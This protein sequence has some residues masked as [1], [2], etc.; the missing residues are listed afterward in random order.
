MLVLTR[1]DNESIQIGDHITIKVMEIS[2]GVVKLGIE[3]SDDTLILRSEL[4][5]MIKNSNL[6]ANQPNSS[7][8][9]Q[10]LTKKLD[11]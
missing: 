3:A 8:V 9:L 1:K 11:K 10:S 4:V 7:E 2:K 5:E 6:K